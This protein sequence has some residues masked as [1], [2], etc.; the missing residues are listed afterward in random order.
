VLSPDDDI[1]ELLGAEVSLGVDGWTQPD[2]RLRVSAVAMNAQRRYAAVQ[3]GGTAGLVQWLRRPR[4]RQHVSF[5]GI[6]VDMTRSGRLL[7]RDLQAASFKVTAPFELADM[8]AASQA[9]YVDMADQRF[10]RLGGRPTKGDALDEA[11]A[12][13]RRRPLGDDTSGRFTYT[14]YSRENDLSPLIAL[15][16][17]NALASAPT[18]PVWAVVQYPGDAP[19]PKIQKMGGLM[20]PTF[21][22]HD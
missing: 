11:V 22:D 20:F 2:G 21:S 13:A 18:A 12:M 7:A 1:D 10:R 16:L 4:H 3:C 14:T 8:A 5:R 9:F 19:A 17:A 15:V 6:G